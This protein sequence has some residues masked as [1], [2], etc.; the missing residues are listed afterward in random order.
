M[1]CEHARLLI[2]RFILDELGEPE[3]KGLAEHLRGCAACTAEL[4]GASRLVGLLATLPD[5]APS[6]AFDAR[7]LAAAIAD[8]ERRHDHRGWLSSLPTQLWRGTVR[9]TG[10]LVLTIVVV[11]L[12]GSA[13]VFAASTVFRGL[14]QFVGLAPRATMPTV[15]TPT[16]APTPLHVVMPVA[17]PSPEPTRAKAAATASPAPTPT[18]RPSPSASP[19]PTPSPTIVVGAPTEAPSSSASPSSSPSPSPSESATPKPRRTPPP[20]PSSTPTTT[21]APSAAPTPSP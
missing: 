20:S 8:R 17:T 21:P 19:S 2:D 18:T 5:V 1:S 4:G 3:R 10:T 7:V 13:F 9:T 14:P 12:V 16:I 15:A 6:D 11:A